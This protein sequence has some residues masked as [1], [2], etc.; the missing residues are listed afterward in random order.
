[1]ENNQV[2]LLLAGVIG[3]IVVVGI[4]KGAART[5]RRNWVLALILI[6]LLTPIWLIWAMIEAL[7]G[8]PTKKTAQVPTIRPPQSTIIPPIDTPLQETRDRSERA[9]SA[10]LASGNQQLIDQ[11]NLMD[12]VA[13]SPHSREPTATSALPSNSAS[14]PPPVEPVN[15]LSMAE[16]MRLR[17]EERKRNHP[18]L[19]AFGHL[20]MVLVLLFC[21]YHAWA[22]SRT[23]FTPE[24]ARCLQDSGDASSE[25]VKGECT[26]QTLRRLY[27][28]D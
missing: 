21:A 2:I 19:W 11:L 26:S 13:S 24:Y 4:L 9:R 5:F 1:M 12:A 25:T 15:V 18:V 3:I 14:L 22:L 6:V 27:Y 7:A 20:T 8:P 17:R 16:K 28:W 23:R 10:I